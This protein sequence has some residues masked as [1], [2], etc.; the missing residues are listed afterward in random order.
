MHVQ[1]VTSADPRTPIPDQLPTGA[2]SSSPLSRRTAA[3]LPRHSKPATRS[4]SAA[5]HDAT[6]VVAALEDIQLRR[7]AIEWLLEA[8]LLGQCLV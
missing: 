2:Q 4:E 3:G 5:D 1:P 6:L 8:G 7:A